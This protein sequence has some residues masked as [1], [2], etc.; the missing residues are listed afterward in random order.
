MLL[1][2]L[3]EYKKNYV[4]NLDAFLKE[5]ELNTEL[6][7]LQVENDKYREL[8]V[9]L[10]NVSK[11]CE[12][13][14]VIKQPCIFINL[15]SVSRLKYI[16]SDLYDQIISEISF[17]QLL[18]LVSI[19]K[20]NKNK[21]KVNEQLLKIYLDK[22]KSI[23]D[24]LSKKLASL[25]QHKN[26]NGFLQNNKILHKT[27]DYLEV[28]QKNY[29][30]EVEY[31]MN[32]TLLREQR[33]YVI[34]SYCNYEDHY[35]SYHIDLCNVFL[36]AVPSDTTLIS[37]KKTLENQLL[38]LRKAYPIPN[39]NIDNLITDINNA[40]DRLEQFSKGKTNDYRSYLFNDAFTIL[41]N[42]LN[43]PRAV[44]HKYN[45]IGSSYW[46]LM[47]QLDYAFD[48]GLFDSDDATNNI[49]FCRDLEEISYIQWHRNEDLNGKYDIAE[50]LFEL[51]SIA[52]IFNEKK[53]N[54][55]ENEKNPYPRI[56]TS[57]VAY[58]KFISL[59]D[60]FGKTPNDLANY[61]FVYHRMVKDK[62][63][64]SDYKQKE[65]VF[66]LLEF[67]I[68]IDRIKPKTQLGNNDLRERIYNGLK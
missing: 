2:T 31:L 9:E 60:E 20:K 25:L 43:K 27:V 68:N 26:K 39:A 4:N 37:A 63:I 8:R 17:E 35:I 23:D 47:N 3:Y 50:D 41:V 7:F 46:Y 52:T 40:F 48:K 11:Y 24:Y 66:F 12:K 65:F 1:S 29:S 54:P 34:D 36:N 56:F 33:D 58:E 16:N 21:V 64:F 61:S 5:F 32:N 22:S 62:F 51:P 14:T 15:S 53:S 30:E 55:N 28:W 6:F 38:A 42:E 49:Y 67:N 19:S 18:E 10:E 59:V 45:D 57:A 44:N 13:I